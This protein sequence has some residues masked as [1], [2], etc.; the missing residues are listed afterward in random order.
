MTCMQW[1]MR[2]KRWRVHTV[3]VQHWSLL[4]GFPLKENRNAGQFGGRFFNPTKISAHIKYHRIQGGLVPT[5]CLIPSW[6]A[7]L[8]I[9]HLHSNLSKNAFP[10]ASSAFIAVWSKAR[11]QKLLEAFSFHDLGPKTFLSRGKA[12][13]TWRYSR[14]HRTSAGRDTWMLTC[15][16]SW[17]LNTHHDGDLHYDK[18]PRT[19]VLGNLPRVAELQFVGPQL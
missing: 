2:C 19:R 18:F 10:C 13:N 16:L 5:E 8:K 15:Q 4:Q 12:F 3:A 7:G 14:L 9:N 17:E 11:M 6:T 1:C